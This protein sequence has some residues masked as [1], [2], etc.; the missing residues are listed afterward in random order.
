MQIILQRLDQCCHDF[1]SECLKQI[2]LEAPIG[3]MPKED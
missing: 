3:Y 1:D 2:L